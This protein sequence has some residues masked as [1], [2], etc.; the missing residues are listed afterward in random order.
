MNGNLPNDESAQVGNVYTL[1]QA[2]FQD[3]AHEGYHP[4]AIAEALMCG[5]RDI[6]TDDAEFMTVFERF[7][8]L[9]LQE[10]PPTSFG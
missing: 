9:H 1:V 4:Q 6:L 7:R 10:T 3:A 5:A 8:T 2:L